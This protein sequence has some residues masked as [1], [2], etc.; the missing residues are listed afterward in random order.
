MK[1]VSNWLR[2]WIVIPLIELALLTAGCAPTQPQEAST[3]VSSVGEWEIAL[4]LGAGGSGTAQNLP[5]PSPGTCVNVR[6]LQEAGL[7]SGSIT[8]R[9]RDHNVVD[10]QGAGWHTIAWYYWERGSANLT[11]LYLNICDPSREAAFIMLYLDGEP[12]R[13][14]N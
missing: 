10:I 9:V 8:W 6:E 2:R 7:R 4:E 14:S 12:D 5:V 11:E 3:Y 1:T 13:S